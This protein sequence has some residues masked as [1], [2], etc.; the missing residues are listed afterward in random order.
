[1]RFSDVESGSM[2]SSSRVLA[3][4]TD[5][6][7]RSERSSGDTGSESTSSASWSMAPEV[8]ETD[9]VPP[10]APHPLRDVVDDELRQLRG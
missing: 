10:R 2:K 1:M 7:D 3:W 9:P 6:V 5:T 8:L 4:D